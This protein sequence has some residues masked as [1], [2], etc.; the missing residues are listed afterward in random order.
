MCSQAF[1]HIMVHSLLKH[2]RIHQHTHNWEKLNWYAAGSL[3]MELPVGLNGTMQVKQAF[4]LYIKKHAAVIK[5]S[6]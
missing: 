4:F 6:S 2:Y 1:K 3:T 5:K